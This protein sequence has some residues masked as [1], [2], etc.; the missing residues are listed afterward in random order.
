MKDYYWPIEHANLKFHLK[1]TIIGYLNTNGGIIFMGIHENTK[2]KNI[3]IK[4][5]ALSNL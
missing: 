5:I 2:N 3:K 4:S 1:K